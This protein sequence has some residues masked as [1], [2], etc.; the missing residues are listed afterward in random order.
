MQTVQISADEYSRLIRNEATMECLGVY[1]NSTEYNDIKYIKSLI[2]Y[3][4][5]Y[6]P[7]TVPADPKM[8]ESF[9]SVGVNPEFKDEPE[10]EEGW[11]E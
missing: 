7:F 5:N 8:P 4:M 1:L 10:T 6:L 2:N 3:A 9:Q 11:H